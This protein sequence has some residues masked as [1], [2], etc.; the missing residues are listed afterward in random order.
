MPA[1]QPQPRTRTSPKSEGALLAEGAFL[2]WL[3]ISR[4]LSRRGRPRRV[5]IISLSPPKRTAAPLAG[6]W[7]DYYPGAATLAR[8]GQ[9]ARTPC[10]VLH[11]MGFFVPR[12]LRA[13]RWALTP[14]FHPDPQL[15]PQAV[16]FL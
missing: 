10:Y 7:C 14:P 5:M 13:G 4:I 6:R 12:S 2:R 16:C 1:S 8:G 3:A 9:A 11:R 15:A